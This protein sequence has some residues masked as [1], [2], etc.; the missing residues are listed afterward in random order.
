M[1][2]VGR[3]V[4]GSP[5]NSDG[6]SDTSWLNRFLS[7]VRRLIP[8]DCPW[9]LRNLLAD[10][11]PRFSSSNRFAGNF[12]LRLHLASI[13]TLPLQTLDTSISTAIP[14]AGVQYETRL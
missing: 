9:K 12:P 14:I 6:A 1:A 2:E 4:P 13:R 5:K 11:P 10:Q 7:D 8:N 3:Y